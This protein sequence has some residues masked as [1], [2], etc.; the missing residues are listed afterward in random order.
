MPGRKEGRK[1][2][3]EGIF[4]ESIQDEP[5]IWINEGVDLPKHNILLL[6]MIQWE[7]FEACLGFIRVSVELRAGSLK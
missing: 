5:D 6:A 4:N 3:K 1:E 2:G 7:G